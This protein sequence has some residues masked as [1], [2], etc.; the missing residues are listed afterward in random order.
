M[1][2]SRWVAGGTE[3]FEMTNESWIMDLVP[4]T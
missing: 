1:N 3:T 2:V 4:S